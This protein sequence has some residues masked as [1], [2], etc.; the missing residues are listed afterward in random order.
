[1]YLRLKFIIDCILSFIKIIITKVETDYF[2]KRH[3]RR[4]WSK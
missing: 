4:Y 2:Y 3:T 1:M